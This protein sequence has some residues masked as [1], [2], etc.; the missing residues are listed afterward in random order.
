M[1]WVYFEVCSPLAAPSGGT[2]C[3]LTLVRATDSAIQEHFVRSEA[4]CL[5]SRK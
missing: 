1:L 2:D 4:T 3:L 5:D